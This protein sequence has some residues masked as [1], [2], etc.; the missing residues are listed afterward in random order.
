MGSVF[1][2]LVDLFESWRSWV[3]F[4]AISLAFSANLVALF[5][6]LLCLADVMFESIWSNL[7]R[8]E[9]ID[10]GRLSGL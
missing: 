7:R 9:V 8:W 4:F 10:V 2:F 6:P 1:L 3:F 5:I